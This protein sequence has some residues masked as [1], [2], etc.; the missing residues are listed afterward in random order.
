[1]KILYVVSTLRQSGPSQVLLNILRHLD[2][3]RYQVVVLTLSPEPEDSM[4]TEYCRYVGSIHSLSLSR[5]AG[6]LRGRRELSRFVAEHDPDIVQTQGIRADTLS[7]RLST[8]ATRVGVI[9]N[10]LYDDYPM[11]YGRLLGLSMARAHLRAWR[12]VERKVACSGA[13]AR[14]VGRHGLSDLVVI[15][16]GVDEEL[17]T[18]ASEPERRA[19]RQKLGLPHEQRVFVSVGAL[20]PRKDPIT[21]MRGFLASE[22]GDSSVL[23]LLG[24]GAWRD[25]C[26]E[27]AQQVCSIRLLGQVENVRDYLRAADYFVSASLS[28]GLPM[29]TLEALACGLPVCLSSIQAHEDIL[30]LGRQAGVTFAPGDPQALARAVDLL[31]AT[32]GEGR[33]TAALEL[34]KGHFTARVMSSRYQMLYERIAGATVCDEACSGK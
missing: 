27:I 23:L 19:L 1:M 34:A 20:I 2:T 31:V 12:K 22:V 25:R 7:S 32:S 18:P 14:A 4:W 33:S 16:N 21:V 3:S 24:D 28:E 29:A 8:R 11:K 17:Y 10:Y 30:S 15:P 26:E 13:V 5:A 6:I 9:H